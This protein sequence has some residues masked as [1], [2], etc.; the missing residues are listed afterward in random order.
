[1]IR[2]L[3]MVALR[4]FVAVVD[5]GGVTRAAGVLNLT[6]SAVSMQIRRLEDM[7]GLRLFDRSTRRI[8]LTPEGEVLLGYARRMLALNDEA[9][10]RLTGDAQE[11]EIVLGV[12]HDIV[13]PAIPQVLHCFAREFP[14]IRVTLVSSFTRVLKAQ[15]ARGEADVILTTEDR[16][17][18]GGETLAELPLVWVGAPRGQAWRQRPLRLAYEQNCLFRARAQAALD[19]AGIPWEMAVES[20]ST[21][22]IEAT[23]SADLAVHTVLAGT[24]PPYVERIAHGGALP[25]L[26][27]MKVNLYLAPTAPTPALVALAGFLRA[28]WAQHQPRAMAR[29]S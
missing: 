7:L 24:E 21:R 1:M 2:N 9:H 19:G 13:Y 12:P 28:A 6:Q 5:C 25:D 18:E 27:G 26:P 3:D 11:G 10:R 14:R 20:D 15:F 16:L 4:S 29:A 17:D 23:V 8:R 22:A